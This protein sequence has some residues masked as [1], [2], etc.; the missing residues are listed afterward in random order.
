MV[1]GI[2]RIIKDSSLLEK[3]KI[4]KILSVNSHA[5]FSEPVIH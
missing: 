2:M 1:L 5:S 3:I 4:V